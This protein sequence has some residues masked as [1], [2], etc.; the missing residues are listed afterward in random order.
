[1]AAP[2]VVQSALAGT[3]GYAGAVLLKTLPAFGSSVTV[4]NTIVVCLAANPASGASVAAATVT[5]NKGNTYTKQVSG[6]CSAGGGV[7]IWTTTVATGGTGLAVSYSGATGGASTWGTATEV[8]GVTGLDGTGTNVTSTTSNFTIPVTTATANDLLFSVGGEN[9]GGGGTVAT[10][11]QTTIAADSE[12]NTT[13]SFNVQTKT[14]SASGAQTIQSGINGNGT[15]NKS[16]GAALAL[17]G[18]AGGGSTFPPI[19]SATLQ[20]APRTNTLLRM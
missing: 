14:V 16:V 2:V 12:G 5:D 20:I 4:G 9:D 8:S 19:P 7:G 11:G 3:N 17:A 18:S 10:T 6:N 15:A 13:A 1:M